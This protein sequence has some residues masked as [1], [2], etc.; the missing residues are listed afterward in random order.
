[1]KLITLPHIANFISSQAMDDLE[2][3]QSII[4]LG[5]K[6]VREFEESADRDT[7]S[8]WI[9]NYLAELILSLDAAKED[10]KVQIQERCFSAILTLWHHR[11]VYQSNHRPFES[12]EPIFKTLEALSPENKKYYYFRDLYEGNMASANEADAT[13]SWIEYSTKADEVARVLISYSLQKAAI[14]A[15][16]KDTTAWLNASMNLLLESD[17]KVIIT[18]LRDGV[19]SDEKEKAAEDLK[20]R[21]DELKDNICKMDQFTEI[22]KHVKSSMANDLERLERG[23]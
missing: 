10:E 7:L 8:R 6:L 1:M 4:R 2:T 19:E 21:K 20:K 14:D 17:L 23:E 5:Q 11:S 15:S 3:Q 22:I 9:A 18:L 16:D 13:K 12:F